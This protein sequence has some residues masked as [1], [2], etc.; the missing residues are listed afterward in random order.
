MELRTF[1][2]F[3]GLRSVFRELLGALAS[4]GNRF[5]LAS[6]YSARALRLLRDAPAPFE[7][8]HLTPLSVAEI[9]ATLPAGPD[10]PASS[11]A[12]REAEND[13]A[14]DE[15]ARLVHALSDGRPSYA[16][17]IADMSASLDVHG[18][19]PVSALSALLA[20]DGAI[21][22]RCRFSYELRLHRARG[23]G[24]LKAI[25]SVLAEEEP[26]T[27]TEIAL[28]LGT[29]ARVDQGLPVVARGCRPHHVA[30][31]ALQLQPTRC[32]GYGCACAAGPC[33][34]AT[35]TCRGRFMRT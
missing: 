20:Q 24:A 31:E 33:R 17:L 32:C 27:L 9:R 8:I 18:A 14:N 19:D 12:I 25:L 35:T 13:R 10:G 6:R 15:L 23:Y 26:L 7:I 16:R 3:P 2:S 21:D 22:A 5:V 4:S 30:P 29:H 28:R 34:P 1:E 11:G